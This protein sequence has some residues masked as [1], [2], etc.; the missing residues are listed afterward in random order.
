MFSTIKSIHN[1][2]NNLVLSGAEKEYRQKKKKKLKATTSHNLQQAKRLEGNC[3]RSESSWKDYKHDWLAYCN[4]EGSGCTIYNAENLTVH[5]HKATARES[6][7]QAC[8]TFSSGCHNEPHS[9]ST[10]NHC[11]MGAMM[12]T[13]YTY[14]T[15][16]YQSVIQIAQIYIQI[17]SNK[18]WTT[19]NNEKLQKKEYWGPGSPDCMGEIY[20][21]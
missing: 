18:S 19:R 12:C 3:C 16:P 21:N 9:L 10:H 8:F 11:R 4:Q 2:N 6:N 1:S 17:L 20:W 13:V 14:N 5:R 15:H 7:Q